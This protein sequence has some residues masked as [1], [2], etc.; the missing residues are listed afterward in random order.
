[1]TSSFPFFMQPDS[2][3]DDQ[4]RKAVAVAIALA[5]NTPLAPQQ[6]ECALLEQYQKGELSLAEVETLLANSV[7][8]LAYR[9]R[10]AQFSTRESLQELLDQAREYN[11]RHDLTGVL[12]YSEGQFVQ[13]LE[14]EKSKVIALYRRILHD[15]RH[16]QL[17]VLS[18]GPGP[19]RHFADWRMAF[20][21]V[22]P[23]ELDAALAAVILQR[24][25]VLP[26]EDPHLRA[27][28]EIVG[29]AKR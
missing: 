10:T 24:P 11:D 18:E 13:V 27:L 20:D 2:L 29:V 16:L 25:P 4:R 17:L 14:G 21:I 3:T 28:L 26:I 8:H 9:S 7:Y 22:S 19:K 1:M 5:S 15:A 6:Y 12:L 23:T